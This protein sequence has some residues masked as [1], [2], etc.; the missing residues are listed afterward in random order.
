MLLTKKALPFS[1]QC[2]LALGLIYLRALA[3]LHTRLPHSRLLTYLWSRQLMRLVNR[4][5][6]LLG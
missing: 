2:S 5:S 4:L 6:S 1:A 3:V